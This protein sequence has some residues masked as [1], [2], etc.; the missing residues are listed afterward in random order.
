MIEFKFLWYWSEVFF[1]RDFFFCNYSPQILVTIMYT[2]RVFS[3]RIS[4]SYHY[5][6]DTWDT[7]KTNK[8]EIWLYQQVV[9][10][11]N[12]SQNPKFLNINIFKRESIN[13]M[14]EWIIFLKLF[15]CNRNANQITLCKKRSMLVMY[16]WMT[17][18]ELFLNDAI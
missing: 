2:L 5:L 17:S 15:A 12:S 16:L 7:L 3:H 18:K 11:K 1:G 8:K 13:S 10:L 4:I 9:V 6:L 14:V